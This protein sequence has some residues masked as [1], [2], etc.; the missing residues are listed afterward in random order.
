MV[1]KTPEELARRVF[2]ARAGFYATS[3]THANAGT[4]GRLV[5]VAQT[6]PAWE[7]LDIA[8]GAGHTAFALAPHLRAVQATDITP[9]M[10]AQGELLAAERGTTN[11]TFSLA[12]AHDLPFSDRSFDLVTCRRAAHHFRDIKRALAEMARV[13]RRP[14]RLVIDDRSVPDDAAVA[15]LMNQLDR[16]HDPSHVREY[17]AAEWQR[18]LS[19]AGFQPEVGE[20]YIE[21][22]PIGSLT[23]GV[24]AGEA[25]LIAE[26]LTA[27]GDHE[28]QVMRLEE[29]GGVLHLNHWYVLLGAAIV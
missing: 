13:L 29:V 10:L 27:A 26:R 7:A 25:Q 11:V 15:A 14:G 12:D 5:E 1:G 17:G 16:W 23:D 19:D 22:R 24:P 28:R 8:T 4:L 2:G 20:G 6:Q 9:E 18:L 21:H 3:A